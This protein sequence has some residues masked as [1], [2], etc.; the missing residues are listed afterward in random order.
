M[1]LT[2]EIHHT[3]TK[4]NSHKKSTNNNDI[5]KAFVPLISTFFSQLL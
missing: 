1:T 2:L 4:N 3:A 5:I